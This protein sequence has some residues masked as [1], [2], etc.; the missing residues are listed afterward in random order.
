MVSTKACLFSSLSLNQLREKV[1][2]GW[3]EQERQ[4]PQFVLFDVKVR[5]VSVPEGSKNDRLEDT[6]CYAQLSDAI[7]AL[8]QKTEFRLIEKLGRDT[9]LALKTLLPDSTPL[10]IRITKENPP[11]PHLEKGASFCFGDWSES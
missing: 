1:R 2:L 10:W 9:Y 6:I 5:F 3:S 4:I 11:I 8:C 7:H